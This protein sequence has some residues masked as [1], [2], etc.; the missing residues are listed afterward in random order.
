MNCR[1][2]S[3][4]V[5]DV[6]RV[7]DGVSWEAIRIHIMNLLLNCNN[8]LVCEFTILEHYHEDISFKIKARYGFRGLLTEC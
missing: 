5:V 8:C 7:L 6:L 2:Q 1:R 3:D 4:L